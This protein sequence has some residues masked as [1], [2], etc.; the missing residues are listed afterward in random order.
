MTQK[1]EKQGSHP[2]TFGRRQG[3]MN[4]DRCFRLESYMQFSVPHITALTLLA[5]L[6]FGCCWH[7]CHDSAQEVCETSSQLVAHGE[8]ACGHDHGQLPAEEG[9]LPAKRHCDG[10]QCSFVRTD[11]S[12]SH[13]D[14]QCDLCQ[15]DVAR[16][17][18]GCEQAEVNGLRAQAG[19]DHDVG[20]PLRTNLLCGVLLI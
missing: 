19:A 4:L 1:R 10:D 11:S 5:H 9:Q 7:P 13:S 15:L 6:L 17:P 14:F 12:P 3:R 20:P 16:L 2:L 8:S 18:V